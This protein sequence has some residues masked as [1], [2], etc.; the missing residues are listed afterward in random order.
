MSCH[1]GSKSS[2]AFNFMEAFALKFCTNSHSLIMK[3]MHHVRLQTRRKKMVR[4]EN[5]NEDYVIYVAL[6]INVSVFH[7]F[8]CIT[9]CRTVVIECITRASRL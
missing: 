7:S 3:M 2:G 9:S 5:T 1:L 6:Y 8:E 4:K